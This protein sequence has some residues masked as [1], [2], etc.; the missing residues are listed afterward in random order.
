M[1]ETVIARF[2]HFVYD[3][4]HAAEDRDFLG[5]SGDFDGYF[6]DFTWQTGFG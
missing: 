4:P 1:G 5:N 6:C 2:S 3:N